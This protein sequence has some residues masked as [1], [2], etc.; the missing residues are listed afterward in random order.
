[1]ASLTNHVNGRGHEE[2]DGPKFVLVTGGAGYIGSHVVLEL[3]KDDRYVPVVVDNLDNSHPECLHRIE[4]LSGKKVP[5]YP[6]DM[7]YK[8]GLREVFK[9]YN[10]SSAIHLAGLK[11]VGE[12]VENP[13]KYYRVNIGI[14]LN[15]VEVMKE[16]GVGKLLFSSSA[17]VYGTPKYLPLDENHETGACSNP[18]GKTKFFVEEMLKDLSEVESDWNIVLLRYFNPIGAHESGEI[19]EDPNGI[20]ANLM[21]FLTQVAVGKRKEAKV[22]GT[23]YPTRDGT[24]I[25]D[26]IHVVDL[27]QGHVAALAKLEE[28]CGC[29]A[30]NLGTGKTVSVLEMIA[31]VE[32]ASGKKVPYVL[33]DKREGDVAEIYCDTTK[34]ETELKWKATRSLD[35]MCADSWNWQRK[36][37]N[38][39]KTA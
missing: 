27:A 15:L 7:M 12:S 8:D 24:G 5:F 20:P 23:D 29:R 34:A 17:T 1:M 3:L 35:G 4:G 28:K 18:Y 26:Y 37:P 36:N 32:K 33:C 6:V 38:G 30:Y 2:E 9:K 19:G 13:M 39:Y 10:F 11:S 16:F 22:F 31:A 14:A 25:R 21:P